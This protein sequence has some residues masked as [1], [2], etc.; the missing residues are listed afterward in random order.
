MEKTSAKDEPNITVSEPSDAVTYVHVGNFVMP[1]EELVAAIDRTYDL[2]NRATELRSEKSLVEH[3][4][5]LLKEQQRRA[6]A[7][8]K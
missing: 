1:N 4:D 2:I 5:A 3:I 6:E 8:G 7:G